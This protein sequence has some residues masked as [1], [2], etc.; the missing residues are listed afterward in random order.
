[1]QIKIDWQ[2]RLITK[3]DSW[4]QNESRHVVQYILHKLKNRH[5]GQNV[6]NPLHN[7][8]SVDDKLNQNIIQHVHTLLW[9]FVIYRHICNR[10]KWLICV[11]WLFWKKEWPKYLFDLFN[12]LITFRRKNNCPVLDFLQKSRNNIGFNPYI[13]LEDEVINLFLFFLKL[14]DKRS[15]VDLNFNHCLHCYKMINGQ[16]P[17]K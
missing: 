16:V 9:P 7:V 1:M 11:Q 13:T 14:L 2:N 12:V 10:K 6:E 8:I 3:E 5:K 17:E 15:P 4:S